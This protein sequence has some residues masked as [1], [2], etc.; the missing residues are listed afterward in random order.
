MARKQRK[1]AIEHTPPDHAH[2]DVVIDA[3]V[4]AHSD[5]E[6]SYY[7]LQALDLIDWVVSE[8]LWWAMDDNGKCAP[9]VETSLIY[10][11]YINTVSPQCP[12]LIIFQNLL[13]RGDRVCFAERPGQALRNEIRKLVPNNP[14]DRVVLG[15][16]CGTGSRWLVSGDLTDFSDEVRTK[17]ESAFDVRITDCSER[18][19]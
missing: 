12:A 4:L 10:T 1:K 19:A 9:A 3:N 5:N 16:A 11:E 14:K 17:C 2:R 18:A 15:A 7:Y 8:D 13:Q 6:D